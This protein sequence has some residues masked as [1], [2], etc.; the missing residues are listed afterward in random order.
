[1]KSIAAL[2][3]TFLL[4][5]GITAP[6]SAAEPGTT[7]LSMGHAPVQEPTVYPPGEGP[8]SD[9]SVSQP[10]PEPVQIGTEQL[11]YNV[12]GYYDP[13]NEYQDCYDLTASEPH[14]QCGTFKEALKRN[15]RDLLNPEPG[16]RYTA[17]Q[18]FR[19]V[20]VT[21]WY[22]PVKGGPAH[23]FLSYPVVLTNPSDVAPLRAKFFNTVNHG[24]VTAQLVSISFVAFDTTKPVVE[25]PTYDYSSG[26]GGGMK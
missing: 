15:K 17:P 7:A 22:A 14:T 5:S 3:V 19:D 20:V 4:T 25:V 9:D 12:S 2:G 13:I 1:M 26:K 6:S 8:G 11:S 21:V 18:N 24:S 23:E 16:V 10:F